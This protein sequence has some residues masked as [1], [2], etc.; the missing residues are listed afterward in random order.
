MQRVRARAR[1]HRT[2]FTVILGSALLLLVALSAPTERCVASQQSE[3]SADRDLLARAAEA[4]PEFLEGLAARQNF[5]GVVF[6]ARGEEV[7]FH[8]AYGLANRGFNVPNRPD[9]RFNL[10]S[11]SKMFT[12]VAIAQLVEKGGLSLDDPV[13]KYLDSDWVSE[14]AGTKIRIKHLLNHTSGLGN[15]WTEEFDN[16]SKLLYR[17]IDDFKRLVSVDPAF[18]PGTKWQY[19]NAGYI[20]L[21]AVIER[22]TGQSYFDYVQK[23]IFDR[24]GMTDTGFY[25]LDRPIPNL[26][27]GYYEDEEDGN[28]LKINYYLHTIR[29]FSAG[30]A[31]STAADMHRFLLALDSGR[32]VD[33][34][35]LELFL[36]PQPLMERYGLGFQLRPDGWV[37][38]SGGFPGIDAYLFIQQSSRRVVIILANYSMSATPVWNE[39]GKLLET[40]GIGVLEKGS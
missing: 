13:G 26:A 39:V 17:E 40:D 1:G 16:S 21:G 28:A 34:K 3:A 18:E 25:D 15:Y 30:G 5:S 37:G 35:T 36:S 20:L 24:V 31:C 32:L 29:G 7:V 38:H 4:L 22:T 6:L 33:V 12:A 2:L 19:S 9:T 8:R 14:E 11:A 10:A 27:V 23:N